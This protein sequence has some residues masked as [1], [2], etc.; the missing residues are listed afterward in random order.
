[1]KHEPKRILITE[2]DSHTFETETE[3][4]PCTK[5]GQLGFEL[6][7]RTRVTRKPSPKDAGKDSS[8]ERPINTVS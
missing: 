4:R 1:M 3:L 5:D 8:S 2:T 7:Q 6:I